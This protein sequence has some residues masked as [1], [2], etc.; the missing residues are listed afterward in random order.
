MVLIEWNRALSVLTV[1]QDRCLQSTQRELR[2]TS[3]RSHTSPLQPDTP[4]EPCI[5]TVNSHRD[6]TL[7][8]AQ[9]VD[10]PP[11]TD[12]SVYLSVCLF[13]SVSFF[14]SLFVIPCCFLSAFLK[15][16]L[17]L[18]QLSTSFSSEIDE[19]EECRPCQGKLNEKAQHYNGTTKCFLNFFI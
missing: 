15:S 6:N 7:I 5:S 13:L 19:C 3:C 17:S 1:F 8:S 4:A 9:S 14:I 18:S 10:V 2:E 11:I 12:V 16:I